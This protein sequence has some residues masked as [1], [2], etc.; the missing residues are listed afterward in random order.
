[1]CLLLPHN[2]GYLDTLWQSVCGGEESAID[3]TVTVIDRFKKK[4]KRI[5]SVRVPFA[6]P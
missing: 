1:M 2:T 5:V 3:H 6:S 4:K